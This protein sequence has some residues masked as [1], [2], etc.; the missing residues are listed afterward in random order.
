M[1]AVIQSGGKQYRVKVGQK[2][3]LEKL[4]VSTGSVVE[5]DKVLMVST[6]GNTRIGAP[7]VDKCS[8]KAEVVDHGRGE[9]IH[10]IKMK[11]RKHHMKSMGHRQSF[12]EIKI[13]DILAA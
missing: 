3:R 9:K 1:Y 11:R 6:E 4:D 7:F 12:T 13:T 8:V 2:V 10:I 5:F